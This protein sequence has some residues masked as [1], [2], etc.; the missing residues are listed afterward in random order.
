MQKGKQIFVCGLPDSG[1]TTWIIQSIFYF[2]ALG[3]DVRIFKPFD[4]G[5]QKKRKLEQESDREIFAKYTNFHSATVNP[6]HFS[7]EA[8]LF[9]ASNF[10]GYLVDLKKVDQS[11]QK[12]SNLGTNTLIEILGGITQP[13]TKKTSLLDWLK[14]Q[15]KNIFWIINS[16]QKKFLWNLAE[17]KILQNFFQIYVIINNYEK[18]CD[19][20][21][22]KELW[23]LIDSQKNCCVVGLIPPIKDND[24]YHQETKKIYQKELNF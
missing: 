7:Q 9:F 5:E 4:I 16:N 2:Q 12:I 24:N 21:W 17:I 8:P 20:N 19:S 1:K 14:N 10:D 18:C 23:T 13:I 3:E 15:T 11:L 22:L 6:Y